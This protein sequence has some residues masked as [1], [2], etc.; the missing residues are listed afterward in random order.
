MAQTGNKYTMVEMD[1][2]KPFNERHDLEDPFDEEFWLKVRWFVASWMQITHA[3]HVSLFWFCKT[4][5]CWSLSS[6]LL[7]EICLVKFYV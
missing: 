1:E 2:Q 7:F 4:W 6:I 3:K 5:S